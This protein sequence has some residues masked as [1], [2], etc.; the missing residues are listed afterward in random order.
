MKTKI[1]LLL[2]CA[3]SLSV[4]AQKKKKKKTKQSDFSITQT[5]SI[6]KKGTQLFLKKV[7]SDARC[8]E[9]ID[10]V[11]A[12][13]AQANISI[14]KNGKWADE[15][16]L[17]FSSKKEEENKQWL[18]QQ[19]GIPLGK[20]KSIRLIPYPKDSI[21]INPKDYQIKVMLNN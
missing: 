12:G 2:L 5:K 16:I 6:Q 11:W 9:G 8:P 1:F 14:Y 13:E 15:T 19:L 3:L 18:S 4:S 7:I 21:K 10:C 20:I 17:T